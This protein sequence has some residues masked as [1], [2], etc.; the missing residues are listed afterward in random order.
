M[1][2]VTFFE[3]IIKGQKILARIINEVNNSAAGR[4]DVKPIIEN[5]QAL[6]FSEENP[7]LAAPKRR[8]RPRRDPNK[9]KV[10][11]APTEYLELKPKRQS[12]PPVRYEPGDTKNLL[13]VVIKQEVED[14]EV[15]QKE[16]DEFI[17]QLGLQPNSSISTVSADYSSL[18]NPESIMDISKLSVI[19]DG[20][21]EVDA[22]NNNVD[23]AQSKVDGIVDDSPLPDGRTLANPD[24][25]VVKEI[26]RIADGHDSDAS[27]KTID[28]VVVK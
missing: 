21:E 25:C 23:A 13:E 20:D 14:A 1:L 5:N 16:S 24:V 15:E 18:T 26:N 7:V 19:M 6:T 22:Q 27:V 11:S 9:P 12:R 8:G 10:Q 28:F 3:K 17:S 2:T 4:D